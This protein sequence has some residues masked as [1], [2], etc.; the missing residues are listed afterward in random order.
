MIRA[1]R[2]FSSARTLVRSYMTSAGRTAARNLIWLGLLSVLGQTC[3]LGVVFLLTSALGRPVFGI[4]ASA[5]TFQSYLLK[6]G[7]VGIK[8]ITVREAAQHPDRLD[9]T[10]TSH[11]VIAGTSS[12]LVGILATVVVW[13]IGWGE[14]DE[15]VLLTI[16]ALGNV[17]ACL[18]IRPLLDAQHQQPKAAGMTFLSE[19]LAMLAIGYLYRTEQ[20][21]LPAIGLVFSVKW[22][23]ACVGQHLFYHF[24][25]RRIRWCYSGSNVRLILASSWPIMLTLL[26]TAIPMTSGVFLVRSMIGDD[27][28][29][30]LGLAQQVAVAYIM[31]LGL[32]SRIVEPHIAGPYGLHRGFL[33]KLILFVAVLSVVLLGLAVA[34]VYVLLNHLINQQY[35]SALMPI[36][37]MLVAGVTVNVGRIGSMYLVVLH[38]ETSVF[39][40]NAIAAILFGL[41]AICL[42]PSFGALGS[43][44][45]SALAVIVGTFIILISARKH[46]GRHTSRIASEE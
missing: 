41:L 27:E 13:V 35:E 21:S 14:F 22:L 40:A 6:L 11:F 45:A 8:Q 18:N 28:T 37:L 2:M 32:C 34:A 29:A 31:L 38:R 15:R 46:V 16:L 39:R 25:V 20:L 26:I 36:C 23:V 43:S 12:S 10:S 17:A 44:V 9:T 1:R 5:L 19:L 7:C 33:K 30:I 4:V 42:I 24:T 3:A